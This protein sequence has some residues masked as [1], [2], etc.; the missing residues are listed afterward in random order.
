[1]NPEEKSREQKALKSSIG[2]DRSSATTLLNT[3][4]DHAIVVITDRQGI[5]TYANSQFSLISGYAPEE[6]LGKT[7]RV[8]NSGYHTKAFWEE[9]WAKISAGETWKGQICNKAKDGRLYWV[10]TTIHSVLDDDG[11]IEK[12]VALRTDITQQKEVETKLRNSQ[13]HLQEASRVAK[14]GSWELDLLT[15]RLSWSWTTKVIHEVPPDYVPDLDTGIEFYPEGVMR[16]RVRLLLQRAISS[17]EPFDEELQILTYTGN[18]KWVRAIGQPEMIDTQCVRLY[19]VFQDIDAERRLQI[20]SEL[21]SAMLNNILNSATEFSVIATDREGIIT[22]FNAGAEKMLGYS[23]A[24]L[25]GNETPAL[26]HLGSEVES[27]GAEL[28]IEYGREVAG[29]ESLAL[30]SLSEGYEQR[31]WTYV[32]KDGQHLP[33]TLVV[34]PMRGAVGEHTGFL[35]IARDISA[36]KRAENELRQSEAQFRRSFEHSGI[37]MA[38]VSLDGKWI[39]VNQ[40]LLDMVGYK[41]KELLGLT[42]QDIT[43]P[44]DLNKDLDLLKETLA[45]KRQNY[46]MEKR[47]FDSE[48]EILWVRLNVSLVR[49][50]EGAPVH[51]V[52]QIENITEQKAHGRQLKEL[53]DRL[54]LAV[55]AGGIGIWDLEIATGKLIWDEQMFQLHGVDSEQFT[56]GF[57]DWKKALHP[58]DFD[59][60]VALAQAAMK[61]EAEFDTD[62]RIVRGDGAIRHLRALAVVERDEDGEAIRMVGTNWDNTDLV[63]QKQAL[64]SLAKE[65]EEASKAK[66][67]FLANMSHEIRTPINGVIGMTALLLDSPGLSSEQMRQAS[68]IKSSGESLLALINDILDFSKVEAG[69]LDL[70][71]LDFEL[72]DVLQDLSLILGQKASEKQLAFVCHAET[73]VPNRLKGDPGR[74][75]QILLNLAGNAIKF[76][77]EGTVEVSVVLESR[78]EGEA[79]LRFSVKDSG[80]GIEEQKKQFLFTEF[81]QVDSSTTRLYGGTGLGLAIC[82]QLVGLMGGDIGVE[83]AL[84]EGSEFWFS[85]RLPYD[86]SEYRSDKSERLS[87]EGRKDEARLSPSGWPTNLEEMTATHFQGRADRILVAEDNVVNQMVVRGILSKF[88]LHADTVAN[89][90]EA[91]EALG[92]ISYDLVLMDVQMPELDGLE[93]CRRIRAGNAGERAKGVPIIALTAHARK[94]DRIAC[95]GAGMNDYLSKPIDPKTLFKALDRMLPSVQNKDSGSFIEDTSSGLGVFDR[96]RFVAGMMDDVELAEDVARVSLIDLGKFRAGLESVFS[97]G[98]S[99][100]LHRTAHSIRGVS[101]HLYCAD[102][103]AFASK[104]EDE[105][106]SGNVDDVRGEHEKLAELMDVAIAAIQSFL[107]E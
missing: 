43:H 107:E 9:L 35:G 30:K 94:E 12:F 16:E 32:R 88:G 8:V 71:I 98:S 103:C 102:L 61:G 54:E 63:E 13:M 66:S 58:D 97:T 84:G 101:A 79:L 7:H 105:I 4:D 80:I 64:E 85:V 95:L 62:F 77:S 45:G 74:L 44:D 56:G 3:L 50:Y 89:G 1:M 42:F 51:F 90:L 59:R 67:Q 20:S 36:M 48:G 57:E 91:L 29:F 47:Y 87:V 83:S 40:S 19:G 75:R 28:S 46:A 15:N 49:D 11:R 24:E 18:L 10:Q 27:R 41:R 14:L 70:E 86:E 65:A 34:T 37:G 81:T 76:T 2:L 104:I 53:W 92:R 73:E 33:V 38:I 78:Y 69:K 39:E 99:V 6:L 17:G 26:I 100:E 106:R 52:S 93:A 60:S 25:V 96:S 55:R 82:K 72:I 5:I 21:N 31:E 23:S 68:V 22:L